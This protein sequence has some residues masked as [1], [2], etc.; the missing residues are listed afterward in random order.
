MSNDLTDDEFACLL[1]RSCGVPLAG[2]FKS[3]HASAC[4]FCNGS[5][6][7]AA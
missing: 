6:Q 5:K 3:G 2:K 1:Y 4:G 7:V